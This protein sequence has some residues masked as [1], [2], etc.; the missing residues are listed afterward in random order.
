V[1]PV[2]RAHDAT[3]R[4]RV[5]QGRRTEDVGVAPAPL[6]P[7]GKL[8]NVHATRGELRMLPFNPDSATLSPGLT[9]VLRRGRAQNAHRL[10]TLRR[11]KRF[12][13][14]TLDGCDT[15][16][17]AQQL[18][19]CEVCVTE[20]DLPAVKPGEIYQYQLIG[21]AVETTAGHHVGVV[22]D[23]VNT[24]SHSVCVVR[25]GDRENLIPMVAPI[26]MTIDRAARRMII[27]PLPGLL[28]E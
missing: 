3:R 27:E 22:A 7:L 16:A 17:A 6:V 1:R 19:G 14:L 28:D 5:P 12:V 8:V 11:H 20:D 4:T 24:A 18:V 10:R 15:M 13:L 2:S 21:M 26:V 25:A 9:V 23:V